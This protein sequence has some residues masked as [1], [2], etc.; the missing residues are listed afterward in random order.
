[1]TT[2]TLTETAVISGVASSPQTD[3]YGHSVRVGAFDASIARRGLV[4]PA[5]VKLL[6]SHTGMPIGR[7]ASLR[8]VG[9]DLRLQAELNMELAHVRDLYSTIKFSGGLSYSVGFRLEDFV[10]VED[11]NL[12]PGEPWLV[13]KR[14]DLT[15]ISVVTFPALAEA[16]MDLAKTAAKSFT[17]T[18]WLAK[19]MAEAGWVRFVAE[20]TAS[21]AAVREKL[22]EVRGVLRKRQRDEEMLRQ[23]RH[24]RDKGLRA[25]WNI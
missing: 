22:A 9:Q 18:P 5:S 20:T 11:K 15:E 3:A 7:I 25:R 12:K 17:P 1:M 23:W 16:T 24:E 19:A 2:A 8:T 21:Q 4:G 6:A 14:G 13:I 10:V